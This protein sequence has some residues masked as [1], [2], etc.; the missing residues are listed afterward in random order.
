MKTK[1]STGV[2][3]YCGRTDVLT[4]DHVP[5]RNLF[6]A[7][8]PNLITVPACKNCNQQASMDDEYFRAMLAMRWDTNYHPDVQEVLPLVM[9]SY[10]RKEAQ[11][12]RKA[13]LRGIQE[14]DVT[15]PAGLY[16]GKA[17]TYCVDLQRLDSVIERTVRGLYFHEA[18]KALPVDV[19][20]TAFAEDGLK[21]LDSTARDR[22]RIMIL[23]PVYS[24]PPKVIGR[25]TFKYWVAFADDVE[26]TSAWILRFYE[27][28]SFVAITTNHSL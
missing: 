16:L 14:I 24:N 2:C 6:S 28:V 22:L 21:D 25:D 3:T 13:L 20:V 26:F 4:K 9:K 19:D 23:E 10:T 8:R 18:G 27:R 15:T 5:P 1:S 11:R 12:Y 17:A 7:P